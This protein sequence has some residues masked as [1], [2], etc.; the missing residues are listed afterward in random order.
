MANEDMHLSATGYAALRRNEGVVM[1]CYH[2]ARVNGNCTW[3][4]GT[5][6]HYGPCTAEELQRTVTPAQVNAILDARVREAE[7]I[8][9]ASVRNQALAQAQFDAAVSF[10]YNSRTVNVQAALAPADR[11][12]L[13]GTARAMMRNVMVIPRD[14]QGHRIGP[15]RINPGLVNRRTRESAPFVRGTP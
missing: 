9:K 2:D 14:P 11:G 12:D 15:G 13:A 6:E 8:V 5:L 1:G 4:V 7:R 10:A 3:G